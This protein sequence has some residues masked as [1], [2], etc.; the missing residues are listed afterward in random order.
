[1]SVCLSLVTMAA[2]ARIKSTDL[3][4]SVWTAG[5]ALVTARNGTH[6]VPTDSVTIMDSALI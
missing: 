6:C 5:L 2:L 3:H 1:M 4:A